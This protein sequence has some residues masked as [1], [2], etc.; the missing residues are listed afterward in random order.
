MFGREFDH[1]PLIF[2][3]NCKEEKVEEE[4][5][6]IDTEKWY[7]GSYTGKNALIQT[8]KEEVKQAAKVGGKIMAKKVGKEYGRQIAKGIATGEFKKI[9]EAA[10]KPGVKNILLRIF[11]AMTLKGNNL[12]FIT[13]EVGQDVIK[14][15]FEYTGKEATKEAMKE[16][17]KEVAEK[18][19][20]ESGKN[21]VKYYTVLE[22]A[23]LIL[24]IVVD[25]N[26][27]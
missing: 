24:K 20:K 12:K 2:L 3:L 17:F 27:T 23:T 13:E 26:L 16:A 18:A 1:P 5:N 8:A 10:I 14:L 11:L 4:S 7:K 9:A 6:Y 25:K 19:V 21:V 15:I 22:G